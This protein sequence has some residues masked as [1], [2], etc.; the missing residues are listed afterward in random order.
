[1]Y[2]S[3]W[4]PLTHATL[5]SCHNEMLVSS[6]MNWVCNVDGMLLRN[7]SEI[8]NYDFGFKNDYIADKP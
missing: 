3:S 1:M 5:V 8:N 6:L 4:F 2:S 7:A